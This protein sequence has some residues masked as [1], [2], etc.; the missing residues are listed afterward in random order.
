MLN[1]LRVNKDG[2]RTLVLRLTINRKR[3]YISLGYQVH[4]KDWNQGDRKLYKSYN[5]ITYKKANED[6]KDKYLNALG[7]INDFN[8]KN[9]PITFQGF[10]NKFKS[11]TTK[12]GVFDFYDYVINE[13]TEK[14]KVG[15][16]AVYEQSKQA[17]KKFTGEKDV[18]FTDIDIAFLNRWETFLWK[19]CSGNGISNYMRTLR[20]LYNRAIDE[21]Y[22][23]R[24]YYPFKNTFNRSGYNIKKLETKTQKRAMTEDEMNKIIS[25]Q[26]PEHSS[27]F[28]T[29]NIFLFSYY[30]MGMN[31]IDIA[32]LKWSDIHEGRIN[33]QRI[34]TKRFYSIKILPPVM[35]ILDYYHDFSGGKGYVFP[36]LSDIHKTEQ[37]KKTRVKIA[38]KKTN[39]ELK[40]IGEVV[41]IENFKSLSTYVARHS[42]GTI[43][44][45]KGVSTSLISEGYGHDSEETTQIYLDEFENKTIDEMNTKLLS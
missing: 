44:K 20:A 10:N 30:T 19:S 14:N 6:I 17:L 33:Y 24:E 4:K 27:L 13:L 21:G 1:P 43:L 37:Q 9:K 38:L 35:E 32:N 16:A 3:T 12:K 23:D 29:K 5:T 18:K 2:T 41:G 45:R 8:K 28:D 39:T 36:I 11:I 26:P 7:I 25:Y 40:E 31:Y 42:W 15:N 34:K 22:C